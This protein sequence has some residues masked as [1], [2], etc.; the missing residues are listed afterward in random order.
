MKKEDP[1]FPMPPGSVYDWQTHSQVSSRIHP[2]HLP[3]PCPRGVIPSAITPVGA[4]VLQTVLDTVLDSYPTEKW[5]TVAFNGGAI[6]VL[7]LYLSQQTST[8]ISRTSR[9]VWDW[10]QRLSL[11]HPTFL[12][13]VGIKFTASRFWLPSGKAYLVAQ[14]HIFE[15][16]ALPDPTDTDWWLE[17][18]L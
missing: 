18:T 1:Y 10:T 6:A 16:K 14:S 4:E 7:S 9:D 17:N 11:Q 3:E 8:P 13:A 5:C 15:K 2:H 12:E